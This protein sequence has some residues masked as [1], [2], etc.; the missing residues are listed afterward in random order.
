MGGAKQ[1]S[2]EAPGESRRPES[3]WEVRGRSGLRAGSSF[4]GSLLVGGKALSGRPADPL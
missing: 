4:G 2:H 1:F 3:R